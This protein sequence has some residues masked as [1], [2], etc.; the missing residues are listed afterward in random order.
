M[1]T[2]GAIIVTCFLVSCMVTFYGVLC[3][4]NEWGK[5]LTAI[6]V[7]GLVTFLLNILLWQLR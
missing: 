5:F 6:G 2:I 3:I 4:Q 1:T 7:V